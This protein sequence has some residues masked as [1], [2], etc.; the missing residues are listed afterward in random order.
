MEVSQERLQE[1]VV[2]QPQGR[3][4]ATNGPVFEAAAMAVIEGGDPEF[5]ID[6]KGVPY[7]S[8]AGLGV[9][10]KTA[11]RARAEGGRIALAGLESSVNMVFEISGF[12]T[13]F[14]V[15]ET[16]QDAVTQLSEDGPC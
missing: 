7:I 14:V 4:D 3:L 16:A 8:S 11:K 9:L 13:L 10:L 15:H 6:M 1:I 2:L 12:L 5:V